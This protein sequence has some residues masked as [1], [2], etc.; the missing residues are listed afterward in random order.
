MAFNSLLSL[1][2]SLAVL[3]VLTVQFP[4]T[5]DTFAQAP[6]AAP[7]D[8]LKSAPFDRLTLT[9]GVVFEIEPLSPRPLPPIE[10]KKKSLAE[11][12]DGAEKP[13][14]RRGDPFERKG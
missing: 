1:S 12:D 7:K 13:R 6:K 9:D 8:L 3:V 4:G 2:L 11:L 14:P 5:R 10:K